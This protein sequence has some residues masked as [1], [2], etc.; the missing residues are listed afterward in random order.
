MRRERCAG[1][2]VAGLATART[3]R[4]PGSRAAACA[5]ARRVAVFMGRRSAKIATRKGKQ[6]QARVKMFSRVGKQIVSAV[7]EGG[8]NPDANKTLAMALDGAARVNFP[9]D[10]IQRLLARA[11]AKDQ[12]DYKRALFEVYAPGGVGVL[13]D[14]F[15]DNN[16]RAMSDIRTVLNRFSV[17][18]A[19]AGSV[20]F[21][22]DRLGCLTIPSLPSGMS[23]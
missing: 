2:H 18:L 10:N 3:M 16:N 12:A 14:V 20:S 6:E 11:T 4:G 8:D 21:N 1:F 19:E 13:I 9:K 17:S 23:S 22:F 7:R 15:T 5:R